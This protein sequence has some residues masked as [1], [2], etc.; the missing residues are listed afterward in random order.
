MISRR[1]LLQSGAVLTASGL[2]TPAKAEISA[3]RRKMLFLRVPGGWDTTRV[4]S[5]VF[6]NP[7]VDM[8]DDAELDMVGDL[9]YVAHPDRP[10]VTDFF[11]RFGEQ[12]AILNGI[13]VPSINHMI[14]NRLLYTANSSATE[15][16]WATRIAAA[17]SEEYPL[18]HVLISG[19]AIGGHQNDLI[20]RVGNNGQLEKLISGELSELS[21][22]E[23]KLPTEHQS[24]ISDLY[25]QQAISRRSKQNVQPRFMDTYNTAIDRAALMQ[26]LSQSIRWDTD[27]S[28][29]SQVDLAIDL[30]LSDLTRSITME[31]YRLSFDSH[32]NNEG[33]DFFHGSS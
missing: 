23:V 21:D 3:A 25:L 27:G 19:K 14:C 10:G 17:N 13:I 24:N 16:D 7:Q 1:R 4:F 33:K 20:V 28:G 30:L 12:T 8:E 32:E 9:Q 29:A 2:I 5:P 6:D 31:F 26:D 11:T 22:L 18:P 15:P